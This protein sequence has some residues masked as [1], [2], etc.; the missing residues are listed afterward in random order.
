MDSFDVLVIGGGPAGYVAA[1]RAAQLGFKTA[2]VDA[3]ERNGKASL[4]GTCLNVG[5]IPS[6]AMLD[7]S[8]KFE[9]MQHDFAEHGINVQGA[10]LD[11]AKM[12]GRKNG[13]VDKLTGGV[14]Y[15][16]KKNKITSFFGLGR[17]VRADG[18]G[19]IVDAAGT[20]V[21]AA[22]VIV[23]TGSSP[24]ALPLAP[25]GGHIVENS[26]ALE[27]TA[28]PEKLG[29]IG[30]GVIGLELGSVWRR[31]GADVTVLEA[32]PGFLMA[33]DDAIAK[34]GLKLFKKQGLDFHF[35]VNITAVEQDDSGVSVT[36]TEQDK[37]VTARFDKLI[38]SIGRVPHTQGLGADAV[39]LAL[40]ERGF[41]KVD[42]HYRTNLQNVYAI[43][44]VIGG[45]MLA[46]KAEEEGVA[47]A[48]MLAGQAGHVNY[49]VI[50]WVIY[51]S[52]EIAW[53]GLTE[54]QA[55]D[56]GLNIK[57]GQFPFSANGRALGHG[58]TRGFV[59][60]IADAQTDKLLGVHMIGGGVSE[61]IGEVV[62]IM[63]F[64]GSSE[65]LAR[66]V[67]AHPTLSEV[68]KEAALAT[69]KRALHM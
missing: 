17:L 49:D 61:L 52:P 3:F 64:G 54:K 24:R 51:T 9:V 32:M 59:K 14:A 25:F 58:D 21:R 8:E 39:G 5:C 10:S 44:D 4:G 53:A 68:V 48:E 42:H 57:T 56:R 38:V 28:V 30:A 11:I 33:A 63:E 31:L 6:K 22:R 29:V 37:E 26:G 41:V 46:H 43:G 55:K 20:E 18:D 65:D 69:D 66:T 34:E 7:S 1:I 16:F 19:W 35:G 13:V 15:L 50:P 2:C 40:D 47:L 23:A 45:A 12:L 36:Y 27:F 67:H 62:A 60:I